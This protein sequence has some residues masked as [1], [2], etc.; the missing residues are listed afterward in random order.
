MLPRITVSPEQFYFPAMLAGFLPHSHHF[1][2]LSQSDLDKVRENENFPEG[3]FSLPRTKAEG[4]DSEMRMHFFL[5][6]NLFLT[7]IILTY[8]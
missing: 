7:F 5:C 4:K 3:H 2:F 8:F 1:V 6:G